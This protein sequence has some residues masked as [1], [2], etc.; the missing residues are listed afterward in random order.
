MAWTRVACQSPWTCPGCLACGGR[1]VVPGGWPANGA[2]TAVF[3]PCRTRSGRAERQCDGKT[4]HVK[5]LQGPW[6][7]RCAGIRGRARAASTKGTCGPTWVIDSGG[8]TSPSCFAL[9]RLDVNAE[10]SLTARSAAHQCC[11]RVGAARAMNGCVPAASN[12][13]T[14]TQPCWG[15]PR[16]AAAVATS[17]EAAL[18][19]RTACPGIAPVT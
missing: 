19:A 2:G 16:H 8:A 6:D 17:E 1:F 4:P 7:A 9:R 15:S 5:R 13:R 14:A 10:V 18:E 3:G 11:C 12:L